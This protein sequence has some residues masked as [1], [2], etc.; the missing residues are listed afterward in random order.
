[1]LLQRFSPLRMASL[2]NTNM[3]AAGASRMSGAAVSSEIVSLDYQDLLSGK[4]L[5]A[6]IERGTQFRTTKVNLSN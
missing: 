2:A 3:K 4:D 1:M 5:T 6:D